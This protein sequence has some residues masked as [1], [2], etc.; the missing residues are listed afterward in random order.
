MPTHIVHWINQAL[1]KQVPPD[2]V[3]SRLG[4]M[5]VFGM[6]NPGC[7]LL[8]PRTAGDFRFFQF[9]NVRLSH[10][11]ATVKADRQFWLNH[12][13]GFWKLD[14]SKIRIAH[15]QHR[16]NHFNFALRARN[17]R[18][19]GGQTPEILLRPVIEWVIVTFGT[20]HSHP[21]KSP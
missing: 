8:S 15:T 18:K 2:P 11:M 6:S 14:T 13:I 20:F 21:K 12:N 9:V 3:C 7:Q 4:K 19:I 5:T 10:A 1:S 16:A 17:L